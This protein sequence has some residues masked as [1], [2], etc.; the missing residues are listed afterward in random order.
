MQKKTEQFLKKIPQ[1]LRWLRRLVTTGALMASSPVFTRLGAPLTFDPLQTLRCYQQPAESD[2]AQSP[3]S[4]PAEP[5]GAVR[6]TAAALLTSS[7][8]GKQVKETMAKPA[9]IGR[10]RRWSR[11]SRRHH[12]NDTQNKIAANSYTLLPALASPNSHSPWWLAAVSHQSR[13]TTR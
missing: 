2:V 6:L 10:S 7:G 12:T 1:P 5:A 3:S 8:G 9:V 13:S 4:A 11:K